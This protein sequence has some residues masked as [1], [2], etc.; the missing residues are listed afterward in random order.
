MKCTDFSM[1]L[2][3]ENVMKID[4]FQNFGFMQSFHDIQ[5]VFSYC[6]GKEFFAHLCRTDYMYKSSRKI[7]QFEALFPC[8]KFSKIVQNQLQSALYDIQT[9]NELTWHRIQ[10]AINVQNN[11]ISW[12]PFV[13]LSIE[14]LCKI[15]S[16]RK[17]KVSETLMDSAL[18][19]CVSFSETFNSLCIKSFYN[20]LCICHH[21]GKVC[22]SQFIVWVNGNGYEI[23]ETLWMEQM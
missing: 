4:N 14:S 5:N 2:V 3:L 19:T 10:T 12:Y 18:P 16:T 15:F 9:W 8:E 11:S 7:I 22:R 6:D 20:T 17:L 13:Y 21:K 1:N 23:N